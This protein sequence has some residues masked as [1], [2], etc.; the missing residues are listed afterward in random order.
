MPKLENSLDGSPAVLPTGSPS[1]TATAAAAVA[2]IS[3][4]AAVGPTPVESSTQVPPA[5]TA[6]ETHR[7]KKQSLKRDRAKVV[8]LEGLQ[9]DPA[10]DLQ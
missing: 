7:T 9:E 6:S 4:S 5:S 3:A 1:A 10:A 8:N 2:A